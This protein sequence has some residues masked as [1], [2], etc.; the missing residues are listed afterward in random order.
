MAGRCVCFDCEREGGDRETEIQ[1][2]RET[3]RQIQ[4][5]RETK[6]TNREMTLN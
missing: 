3:K 6:M 5:D 4:K 1:K 2:D